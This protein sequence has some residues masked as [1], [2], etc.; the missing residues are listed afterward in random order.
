[1]A[2]LKILNSHNN[3]QEK[4]GVRIDLLHKD[5]PDADAESIEQGWK[6]YYLGQI[7]EYLEK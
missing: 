5:V 3:Y 2:I 4:D 1:M 7:K 6:E